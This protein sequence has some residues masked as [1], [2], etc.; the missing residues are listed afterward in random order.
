MV[1]Q[2]LPRLLKQARGVYIDGEVPSGSE[3][4]QLPAYKEAVQEKKVHNVSKYTHEA[5]WVKSSSELNLMR[6]AAG[7]ACQVRL[8]CQNMEIL[9]HLVTH[10]PPRFQC[11]QQAT[12]NLYKCT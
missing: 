9:A 6:H 5:R 11:M 3:L 2:H 4:G 1:L 12:H 8:S 10:I 7:M